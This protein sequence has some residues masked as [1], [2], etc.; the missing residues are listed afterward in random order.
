MPSL[1]SQAGDAARFA[2]EEFFH[3]QIR[4][5][6]TRKAYLHALRVF[7]DWCHQRGIELVRVMPGHVGRYLDALDVAVPTRKV[8]LAAL[9][10][11]FDELV[12]RHVII[13]NPALSVRSER[14]QAVEGKT[15]EI[16][17]EHA[18]RLLKGLE[19][20]HSVGLR[21]R[22][23]IGILIY[24]AARVG[25]V[26]KLRRSDFYEVADQHCLR[27][28]P[29]NSRWPSFARSCSAPAI[30]AI[31]SSTHSAVPAPLAS[32]LRKVIAASLGSS[33]TVVSRTEHIAEFSRNCTPPTQRHPEPHPVPTAQTDLVEAAVKR[34]KT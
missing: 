3:G 18:R 23:I 1:V 30:P 19:V 13:L 2:F 29:L 24:T 20:T 32:P 27:F 16:A 28:S 31:S 6:H 4:N 22:A 26:A 11:F 14:Y 7:S 25:A 5:P 17:I 10:R 15:P 12:M 34:A 33:V 9:R 8:H 21:D